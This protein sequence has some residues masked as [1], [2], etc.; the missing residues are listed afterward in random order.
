[1]TDTRPQQIK[2]FTC[3]MHTNEWYLGSSPSGPDAPRPQDRPFVPH[4]LLLHKRGPVP[5][6]NFQM[7]PVFSFLIS[8]GS[9]KKKPRYECL[10]EAR[11]SHKT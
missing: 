9:K 2:N 8:S 7:A 5:L 6:A 3:F 1:M 10:S 11:A 4:V